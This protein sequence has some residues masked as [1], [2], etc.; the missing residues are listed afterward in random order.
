[1]V[2]QTKKFQYRLVQVLF[3]QGLK[4]V[5]FR[6]PYLLNGSGSL[7]KLPNKMREMDVRH[8]LIVASGTIYRSGALDK[9]LKLLTENNMK[10][11]IYS[12]VK[13]NPTIDNIEECL[14]YY[15]ENNCDAVVSIG[16]GSPMDCSKVVAALANGKNTS[17]RKLRGYMKVKG[18]LPKLFLCPTTAGSGSETTVAA[19]I[20]D[21][22]THEKY[23]VSDPKFIPDVEVLD[24]DL[25]LNLP[26]HT[27][28]STGMDALTHAIEAYMG[29]SGT[30]YTDELSLKAIKMIFEN[31]ET[32][33]NDGHNIKARENM[34]LASNYAGKA[35]T[36]AFVGYVH[37]IA[38]ALGG[39]YNVPHGLA[40]AIILPYV[41]QFYG[42]SIYDK[43]ATVAV[44]CGMGKDSEDKKSLY[45][46]VIKKINDMNGNM[47][48]PSTVKELKEE[49]FDEIIKRV[50][51]EANPAYPVPK[52]MGYEECREILEKLKI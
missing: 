28:A 40:N 15:K 48:I 45:D 44:Y 23:A 29:R 30:K 35:F 39:L 4:F 41:L 8:P 2:S 34:L 31:L 5:K 26:Q 50:L 19:V 33:Y 9:F 12:S 17:V 36:R 16:G 20:T 22:K 49:D 10:Y 47:N 7:E 37:A 43:M 24:A 1:M 21:S 52:I 38:H 18:T 32:A 46:K 11:T 3:K 13:P 6:E 42:E 14:S 27:T 25:T 51:K